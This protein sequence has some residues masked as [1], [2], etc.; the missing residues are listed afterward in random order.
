VRAGRHEDA[1]EQP[2]GTYDR[3]GFPVHIRVPAR[4]IR[5]VQDDDAASRGRDAGVNVL[6]IVATSAPSADVRTTVRVTSNDGSVKTLDA[7]SSV[8]ATIAFS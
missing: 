4:I 8:G 2:V 1:T 6:R 3:F 5:I 7:A